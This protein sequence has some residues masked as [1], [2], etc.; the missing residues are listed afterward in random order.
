[1]IAERA[2]YYAYR[3]GAA[4]ANALPERVA[5]PIAE[6][7]GRA[8]APFLGGRR[9]LVARNLGRATSG[10]LEGRALQRA[11]SD[12]FASY[13]RYWLELFRLPKDARHSVEPRFD[14]DGWE[15]IEAALVAGNGLILALPHLGGFDFAA[16][17]LAGRGVAPTVVVEPVEPPELFTWFASV[18]EAIGM[19]VVPLGPDAGAAV[20][21]AL[22][23]N[24]IVCL[25]SDRDLAGDG[26]D[27]EFF[28]ERTTMPG[29][30]AMLSLRT[31]APLVPAGV[32]FR[33]H[34]KHFAKIGPPVSVHREGRLRDDV[35]R[36]TQELARRFEELIALA[37][38]QWHLMQP[39]W[40]S[41]R[42]PTDP[43]PNH[44]PPTPGAV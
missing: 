32:Y 12:T 3:S 44:P 28:G 42:L 39:N 17:W 9:R 23:A 10:Q 36:V 5:M 19:E 34:G 37:P 40:P 1:V 14:A 13:G 22:K 31:G 29:G 20:L 25:L 38:E 18:R 7:A 33:P 43:L 11:V 41:D 4:L 26:V 24:R 16:A 27:V 15:H 21:R 35:A 6:G 8:L 30:P 2:S